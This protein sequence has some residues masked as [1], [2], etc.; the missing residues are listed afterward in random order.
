MTFPAC[1]LGSRMECEPLALNLTECPVESPD[2]SPLVAL[3][4]QQVAV[5][6]GPKVL[7]KALLPAGPVLAPLAWIVGAG[8]DEQIVLGEPLGR[9]V[10]LHVGEPARHPGHV[11]VE[12]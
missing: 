2:R 1:E 4:Y 3:L 8:D 7:Q 9:D 12:L 10:D 6:P 11:A 5:V